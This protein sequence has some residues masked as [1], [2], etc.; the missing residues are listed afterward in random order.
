MVFSN[1][2][3]SHRFFALLW[4]FSIPFSN[5]ILLSFTWNTYL[6]CRL[7][8]CFWVSFIVLLLLYHIEVDRK[9]SFDTCWHRLVPLMSR[10]SW[11]LESLLRRKWSDSRSV[12]RKPKPKPFQKKAWANN[13]KL[14]VFYYTHAF[15]SQSFSL[16]S[17]FCFF[18]WNSF[19][20]QIKI[21]SVTVWWH[22]RQQYFWCV[23]ASDYVAVTFILLMMLFCTLILLYQWNGE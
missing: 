13:L 16:L 8:L 14:W 19:D 20:D 2:R 4:L 12:K 7:K 1:H 18:K 10:L 3:F 5:T 17:L 6:N 22:R 21:H 23:S 11:M 15:V 9:S